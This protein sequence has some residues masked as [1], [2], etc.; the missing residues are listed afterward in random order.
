MRCVVISCCVLKNLRN[1]CINYYS[2]DPSNYL[3]APSL[4]WDAMLLHTRVKL[5]LISNSDIL[6]MVEKMKRGGLCFVGLK[7]YVKADNKYM[8]DCDTNEKY[9]I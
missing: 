2:L 3:T 4:A 1:M 5:D 8:P 6:L 9:K 7:R